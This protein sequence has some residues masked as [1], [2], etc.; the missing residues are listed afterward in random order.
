MRTHFSMLALVLVIGCG[1]G[2]SSSQESTTGGETTGNEPAGESQT[3]PGSGATERA[4]LTP[5]ECTAQGGTVVGDIG[6]GAT[7]RPD[8]VCPSGGAPIG[9]VPSG[10]EGSVCCP[11]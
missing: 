6:D 8:Y 7:L 2:S 9:N 1:G 10:I 3:E 11:S 5:D 4:L